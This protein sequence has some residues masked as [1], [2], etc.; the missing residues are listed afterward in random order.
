MKK[1]LLVVC[2]LSFGFSYAQPGGGGG[3]GGSQ[4][5]RGQSNQQRE[6]PE[7]KTF[8][9][10]KLAGIF[11]YD[12]DAAIKKIKIKKNPE[13]ILSVRKSIINYNN[14]INEIA[15]LNKDNFDTLNV[16]MNAIIKTSK[17]SSGNQDQRDMSHSDDNPMRVAQNKA[18]AKIDPVKNAVKKEEEKLNKQLKALLSE[19]K[20]SKWLKYQAQVK[21]DLNPKETSSESSD[22][23]DSRSGGAPNGGG[24]GGMR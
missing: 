10:S 23:S 3:M 17:R 4:S 5:G 1:F 11:N 8:E 21:A 14:R 12:D 20:Y 6:K 15:L 24:R 2:V 9:A 13:L 18:K 16:Y 22:S 7:M 19:K